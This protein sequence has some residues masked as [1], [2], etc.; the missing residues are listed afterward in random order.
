M[1]IKYSRSKMIVGLITAAALNQ[2]RKDKHSRGVK[3]H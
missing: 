3:M 2:E 1:L